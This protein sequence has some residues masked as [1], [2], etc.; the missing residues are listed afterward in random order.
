MTVSRVTVQLWLGVAE[1]CAFYVPPCVIVTGGGGSGTFEMD[2]G[3]NCVS[4]L[5]SLAVEGMEVSN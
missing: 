3:S 4:V 5:S 1:Y 2:E